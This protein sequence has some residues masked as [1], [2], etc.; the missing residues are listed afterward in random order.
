MQKTN[1]ELR[2]TGATHK[3]KCSTELLRRII[4]FAED[5]P[6]L[7]EEDKDSVIDGLAEW[8]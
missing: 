4:K 5:C 7:S 2:S 8:I 3:G 6:V 1:V